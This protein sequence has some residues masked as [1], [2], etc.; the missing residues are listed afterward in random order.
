MWQEVKGFRLYLLAG[1]RISHLISWH[2]IKDDKELAADLLKI[3]DGDLVIC[4]GLL[5]TRSILFKWP[6]TVHHSFPRGAVRSELLRHDINCERHLEMLAG[7]VTG[8]EP[9]YSTT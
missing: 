5:S 1:E 4:E 8:W 6:G 9:N 2:Q 7:M 3:K